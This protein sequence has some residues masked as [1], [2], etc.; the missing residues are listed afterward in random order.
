MSAQ[1]IVVGVVGALVGLGEL[2]MLPVVWRGWFTRR[3]TR[4]RG[5]LISH[6]DAAFMFWGGPIFRRGLARAFVP[7]MLA[8]CG[9]VVGYWVA[10]LN[11]GAAGASAPDAAKVAAMVTAAW[12]GVWFVVAA[13]IVLFSRPKL[14]VPPPQRGEPGALAE[15]RSARRKRSPRRQGPKASARR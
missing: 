2:V 10:A 6:G 9:G 7:V 15:W 14:L 1:E 11:G 12:L 5:R 3:K 4:F 13:A 8:W